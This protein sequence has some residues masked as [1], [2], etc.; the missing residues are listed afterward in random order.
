M[1]QTNLRT[2]GSQV[3]IGSHRKSRSFLNDKEPLVVPKDPNSS[4]YLN[5]KVEKKILSSLLGPEDPSPANYQFSANIEKKT[6]AAR[7][8]PV[9][10]SGEHLGKPLVPETAIESYIK[11]G[12]FPLYGITKNL[13]YLKASSLFNDT[14][15]FENDALS[16]FCRT[17]KGLLA[18]TNQVVL[19]LTFKPKVAGTNLITF[20]E[21]EASIRVEPENL[22]VQDFSQ[23]AEQSVYFAPEDRRLIDG[24]PVINVSIGPRGAEENLRIVLPFTINKYLRGEPLSLD[25]VMRYLESVG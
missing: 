9:R 14:I 23:P 13:L 1:K 10:E 2:T 21:S 25:Q 12:Q 7:A 11:L 8:N 17:E 22:L 5:K 20:L 3:P 18:Q 24:F 4:T 15:L 16:L 6:V 19:V